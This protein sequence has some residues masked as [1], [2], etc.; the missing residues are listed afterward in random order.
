M[1]LRGIVVTL[2]VALQVVKLDASVE[3]DACPNVKSFVRWIQEFEN[4]CE[5]F[6][7]TTG[8]PLYE[9]C[10]WVHCPCI[11]V[12]LQVPVEVEYV[13]VCYVSCLN[14]SRFTDLQRRSVSELLRGTAC[15]PVMQDLSAPC[16][17]CDRY[18]IE[19]PLCV[20]GTLPPREF[21]TPASANSPTLESPP[22]SL[23]SRFLAP[24][25]ARSSPCE[26]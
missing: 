15:G 24:P 13:D 25:A 5:P 2:G 16:G 1:A 20:N 19:R 10:E 18:A 9:S 8:D 26:A 22:A 12:A 7:A 6:N 14:A 23:P 3:E 4:A 21:F 11:E 17:G